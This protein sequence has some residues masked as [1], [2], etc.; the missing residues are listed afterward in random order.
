MSKGYR[1]RVYASYFTTTFSTAN[2]V[3]DA[4]YRRSARALRQIIL[5]W[6]PGDRSASLLDVACGVG[7]TVEMLR[8]EGYSNVTGI[9]LSPEQVHLARRRGLPVRQEDVFEHL[10]GK[11]SAYDVI[12]AF[13]FLE[14]LHRDELIRFLDL[15]REALRPGGRLLVK[16]PN[17]NSPLATRMRWLDLTHE[18]IFTDRSLRAAFLTCNLRPVAVTGQ[19]FWPFT[20]GGW[21]RLGISSVLHTLWKLYLIADLGREGR[22]LPVEFDLIGVAERP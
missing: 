13:D 14:H 15:T 8:E 11:P 2:E 5:P 4:A 21:V 7:F 6:I 10:D 20:P 9:D 1:D 18:N 19:H 3:S 17:A 16:T 12:L 22:G